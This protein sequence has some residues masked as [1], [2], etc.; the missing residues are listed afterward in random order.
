MDGVH[1][2]AVPAPS[3]ARALPAGRGT[4][5]SASQHRA[6]LRGYVHHPLRHHSES[7]TRQL[8]THPHALRRAFRCPPAAGALPRDADERLSLL[9]VGADALECPAAEVAPLGQNHP[10]NARRLRAQRGNRVRPVPLRAGACGDGRRD[11]QHLGRVHRFHLAAHRPRHRKIQRKGSAH[12]HDP[13]HHR[14]TISPYRQSCYL[15]RRSARRKGGLACHLYVG[16]ISRSCCRSSSR[17]SARCL[18]PG[19]TLRCSL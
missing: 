4:E 1:F 3:L 11:L 6:R 12:E 7:H 15:R 17:P 13:D 10:H 8:R 5:T 19:K 16:P 9:P 2:A 18:L 14:N